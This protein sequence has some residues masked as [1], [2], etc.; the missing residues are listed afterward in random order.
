MAENEKKFEG[1]LVSEEEQVKELVEEIETYDRRI[2]SFQKDV[3]QLE[4]DLQDED[5]L[6]AEKVSEEL[7]KFPDSTPKGLLDKIYK[8]SL[9]KRGQLKESLNK[10]EIAIGHTQIK[11]RKVVA[12]KAALEEK[13][14]EERDIEE[15][16]QLFSVMQ[17][18]ICKYQA[19]KA[20]F[21]DFKNQVAMASDNWA[22]RIQNYWQEEG[23][24]KDLMT[25][26]LFLG[27]SHLKRGSLGGLSLTHFI[28]Q[29]AGVASSYDPNPLDLMKDVTRQT[30]PKWIG[31]GEYP[32]ESFQQGEDTTPAAAEAAGD[33]AALNRAAEIFSNE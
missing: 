18:A 7:D 26:L 3:P 19:C 31:Q 5:R 13:I 24:S 17:E 8:L 20:F 14:K 25:V 27:D 21:D 1:R 10:L 22:L 11:R 16:K 4:S 6:I 28:E 32:D 12:K 9:P 15:S 23:M 2:E 29:A 33:Q 30:G